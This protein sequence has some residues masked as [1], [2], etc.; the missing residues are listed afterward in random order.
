MEQNPKISIII[1]AYNVEKYISQCL[2]SLVNQTYK[3]IEIIVINDGSNDRTLS[4]IQNYAKEDKRICVINQNNQGLSESRN[5]GFKIVSGEYVMFADSDDWVETDMCESCL[6]EMQKENADLVLFS[7]IR[8]YENKSILKSQFDSKRIVFENDDVKY[9]LQRRIFGPYEGNELS[10]PEKLDSLSTAWGKMYKYDCIKNHF[11]KSFKEI[12]ATC[13]DVFFNIEIMPNINKAIFIDKHLYHYR[14]FNSNSLTK[15][16]EPDLFEKW[17]KAYYLLKDIIK[18]N[19]YDASY[20]IALNNRFA[21]NIIAIG[22]R[23]MNGSNSFKDKYKMIKNILYDKTYHNSCK[24]LNV[25]TMPLH[26]KLFFWS[27]KNK[28]T[29]LLFFLFSII[30]KLASKK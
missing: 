27:A 24:N 6:S 13:E 15:S 3:N 18:N 16:V 28:N 7:Y 21:I 22:Q 8:E 26:W 12:A 2:D 19:E 4:I 25:S 17:E 9:K 29:I 11:F 20:N 10:H 14:K 23:I 30:C 1:P 5:N